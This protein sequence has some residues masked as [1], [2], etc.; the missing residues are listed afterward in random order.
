MP[1]LNCSRISWNSRCSSSVLRLPPVDP[2]PGVARRGL[3]EDHRAEIDEARRPRDG[4]LAGPAA[5]APAAARS[6]TEPGRSR[7][8]G[9]GGDRRPRAP[10]ARRSPPR[11]ARW[12]DRAPGPGRTRRAPCRWRR[13]GR[14]RRPAPGTPRAAGRARRSGTPAPPASGGGGW[15]RARAPPAGRAI[16]AAPVQSSERL[17]RLPAT[18]GALRPRVPARRPASSWSRQLTVQVGIVRIVGDP[19][20]EL[21]PRS[22]ATGPPAWAGPR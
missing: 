9:G 2:H 18:A 5:P 11:R 13:R 20:L 17:V 1:R 7:T 15:R 16:P 22:S 14:A 4:G 10:T 3:V 8:L 12:R 6:G 19:V 21:R